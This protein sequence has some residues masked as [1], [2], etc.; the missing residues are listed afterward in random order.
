[1]LG[2]G[3]GG[4]YS[5]AAALSAFWDALFAG[6][7]VSP[8]RVAQVVRPRSDW[9]KESQRY[10][11]GFHLHGTVVRRRRQLAWSHMYLRQSAGRLPEMQPAITIETRSPRRDQRDRVR[12]GLATQPRGHIAGDDG[13]P[14]Q[15]IIG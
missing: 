1:M 6:R 13:S 2:S 7:I 9:P 5:T 8:Q 10:G 4:I 11:L 12:V 15:E 14:A 3:D